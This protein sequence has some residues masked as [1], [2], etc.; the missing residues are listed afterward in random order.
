MKLFR[1]VTLHPAGTNVDL[2]KD[3]GQIPYTLC[4]NY[5]IEAE[6]VACHIDK[7]NANITA[8]S[9]LKVKHIP[10]IVNNALSGLFYLIFNSK[11]IDW[12]NIYFAGRQAYIWTKIFKTLNHRGKV[13]LKLDMDFRSSDLYD[14]DNRE[15]KIF[16]K[17]TDVV[18]LVS[19]ESEAL[20]NRIQKYSSKEIYVIGNGISKPDFNPIT[21]QARSN[22]FLTVARLGTKQ[23]AT[24]ILLQ[25][26]AKTA[27][28]HNWNLVL[29]GTIE[30]EFKKYIDKF[31]KEYPELKG[32][33]QF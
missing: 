19:V 20:K 16:Y 32:R 14:R 23:K 30:E 13:Y 9:G 3:E 18:D 22:T 5:P 2:M 25:G 11:K 8:V 29:I 26:F 7:K 33:I 27:N 6:I 12:L 31:F 10:Y 1:F 28:K 4:C 21:N 24:D 17:C 15:R